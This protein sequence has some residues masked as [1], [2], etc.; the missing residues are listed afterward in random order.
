MT[1]E[2]VNESSRELQKPIE[3]NQ[4]NKADSRR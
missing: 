3:W 1:Q 4:A 2:V